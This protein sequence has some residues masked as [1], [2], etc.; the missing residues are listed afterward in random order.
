MIYAILIALYVIPAF[1]NWIYVHLAYSK[2]GIFSGLNPDLNDLFFTVT[3]LVN[4]ISL[5]QW[6]ANFPIELGNGLSKFF[7]IKK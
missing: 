6:P 3:P 1:L 7:R 2:K 4:I 5:I